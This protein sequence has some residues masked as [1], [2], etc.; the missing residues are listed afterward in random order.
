MGTRVCDVRSGREG[1]ERLIETRWRFS[2]IETYRVPRKHG[3]VP[4]IVVELPVDRA[5]VG[6]RLNGTRAGIFVI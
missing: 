4:S 1:Y 5:R 3:R 6:Q 2:G